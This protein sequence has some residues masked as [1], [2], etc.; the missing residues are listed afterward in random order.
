MHIRPAIKNTPL[1]IIA[2]IELNAGS[3]KPR[4]KVFSYSIE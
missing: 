3:K 1:I 4:F 2:L